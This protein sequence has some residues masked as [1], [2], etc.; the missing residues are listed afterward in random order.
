MPAHATCH[1]RAVVIAKSD[2]A[3]T[4]LTERGFVG[5]AGEASP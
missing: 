1:Y 5:A 3:V 4:R 2:A